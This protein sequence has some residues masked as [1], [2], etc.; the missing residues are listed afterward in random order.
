MKTPFSRSFSFLRFP[1]S[2]FLFFSTLFLTQCGKLNE[3]RVVGRNFE[4]EINLAQN[5]VF[6]FNKDIVPASELNSW[7]STKF[8]EFIPAVAGKFKWTAPNE[9][10]FSPASGF[11]PATEYRAEL[12]KELAKK[13]TDKKYGVSGEEIEF[14]T[15]Y[16]QLTDAETYWT[17]SRESGKPLAKTK[18]HFNYGVNGNEVV[19]KLKV[20][21]EDKSFRSSTTQ[22][23]P[24]EAITVV[25][26]DAAADK[27]E[28]PLE[29]SVEKGVKVPN[30]AYTTKEEI[31]L[32]GTIPSA[33]TLEV[34]DVK[35]GFENYRGVVRIIT[36][37]ELQNVDLA[38]YY[39][40]QPAV[41]T[42][43]ELTENGFTIRGDFNET[44]TYVLTLTDQVKGVLGAHLEE[45]ITKDLFFGNMPAS[46]S[47]VN[48]KAIYLSS[49]GA[50]NVGVQVVNIP[51]VQVKIAK[52]YE[53]NILQY[54]RTNRYEEYG[55]LGGEDN[56]GPTG[57]YTYEDDYNQVYSDI[58]VDKTIETDNLPKVKG[59][60]A[61]NLGLPDAP[62]AFRGI[63]VVTVQSKDEQYQRAVKMVSLSDIGLI[64]KQ[65]QD[66]FWVF[67][68][69]IKTAEPLDNL[70][71]S[72]IS[73]NNQT[74]LTGRT[75]SRGVA[76]FEKL[77]EKAPNFTIAMVIAK[78]APSKNNIDDDF[79]YLFLEDTQVETSRFE[80]EGKRDNTSGF[81][82]FIYG[83]RDIYRPG[84]TIHFNTV[85]RQQT[86]KSVGEIPLK[87]KVLLPNGKEL[88]SYR[89]NTNS[90]GAVE[91]SLVLDKAAVTGGYSVE[92]Y[93]GNDVLLASKKLNIEEFMPD[94]IKV[95][96]KTNQE[97]YR[98]GQAISLNATALNLFGP[99][100]SGR[101][102]EMEFSLKRKAFFA[103]RYKEYIFDMPDNATKFESVVRQ[104]VTDDNGLAKETFPL[105][106]EYQD[107]GVLEGKIYVTVFDETGRPV[108]RLKR[109][110][111]FTQDVFYGVKMAD[112]YVG[113]NAPVPIGLVAVDKD[114]KPKAT[115]TAQVEVIRMDY[116]TVVEKQN[117]QLRYASKKR[118]KIVYSNVVSF[119]NGLAE[120][121][122]V[123]TVSGEYEVRIRR[124]GSTGYSVINFYAYGWGSTSASSF[125]VSNEGEV[126]M[127][128]DKPNYKVGD[129]A[130]VLFKT[131][132]V[133]KLLVTVERNKVLEHHYL[134][135]DNKSAAFS[136]SVGS[137]HLPNAF[138]TAT[139]IRPLDNSNLPLTVAHGFASVKVEDDDTK[140]PVE[141]V[142][143]EKSRSKTKQKIRIKTAR[144]AQVT[145]AVVDE[146]IL[147]IKNFQTPDIHGFFY[148][149]RAL[150]VNSHDL[151]PFLF[152]ELSLASASSVGGDGY[153][154]EKRINPLSNGRVNLVAYW[155]G[156]IDAGF[157][158][159]AE[160][161]VDIP[162]FSGDL[163]IMAVAYKD[164]AF[165]SGNKNMKVA[166]PIVISTALPRFLSPDDE[167]I[168]PVNVT[169]TEKTAANV[170][171]SI[172][173]NGQLQNLQGKTQT[174]SI[175][176]EK[177]SRTAFVVKAA[178]AMGMGSVTVTVNNGKEKFVEKTELTIRP[179]TSL[180]KTSQSGIIAGGSAGTVDLSGNGFIPSTVSSKLVVSRSPMVQYAKALDY[181]LGYPHGC[182]EQT[183][184]KA[185][186]QLYFADIAKS[187]APKTYVVKTGESDF[188]P[189]FNVQAAIQKV[190]SM[191]LPNGAVSY[192]PAGT[193]ESPWGTAYATHFLL[194]AQRAGFEIN[195]SAVG[196][197]LD[198]LTVK[199][200][201][202]ATEYD[203]VYDE[204]S[205]Y[206][207]V[208]IGS[209]SSLYS[210]YALALGGKANRA[211]MNYY[212]QNQQL[213]TSD[214]RYLLA[215][216]FKQIGDE[217]SYY[218]LLP[219]T[220]AET[221]SSRQLSGSFASPIRNIALTLNTLIETDPNNIQ[222]P[223]LARRLS[224][225]LNSTAYLN[226]QEAAFSFLALGKLA[227][228]N[229]GSTVTAVVSSEKR[230]VSKFDGKDLIIT[231]PLNQK[232]QITASGKGPLY[233]FAQSEGLSA[234]GA[235]VEEDAGLR[236]RKQFLNRNGQPLSA[237]HQ[238]DLVVVKITLTST[239]GSPVEN[240][241]VT[242]LLPAAFEVEN[243][244]L[245]EPRDMPWIKNPTTPDHFDIRDDRIN[246]YTTA[247]NVEKTFYYMVRVITKGTFTLGPVSA[248]A[249]YSGDFRSYSGGGKVKVY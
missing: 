83:D 13:T 222:I 94:R 157:D 161:E 105:P 212:K 227:K 243:P 236:V 19:S 178:Q 48:K 112:N 231:K 89:L 88:K 58:I 153:D 100:A 248:D 207:Q 235:Y 192:W 123:P 213:L 73:S 80:V 150:E 51:K 239:D 126:L 44:D 224:Q 147:Q 59:V 7:E 52:I 111:V 131:P 34:K 16:L 46:I 188:N 65:G 182:I 43:A 155:S 184:S 30:T 116:Q 66:E 97:F 23:Q 18:L 217:R 20:K 79:N 194:E 247:N 148:Q 27:N 176:P 159:E 149:K 98:T 62:N 203:Y 133:G 69:S 129:K 168:V 172:S 223:T 151:Y 29:F 15:P 87:I 128:F 25:L 216:A 81:E 14:H 114:G 165:G 85:V 82:A 156:Q 50:R 167:L 190:E 221:R 60:S 67:A 245:T 220:L 17:K 175:A 21:S 215:A 127:E 2:I 84:E 125:E 140:L 199:T 75:D 146:G 121:R 166:D 110:D 109:F 5:L 186:P 92:V 135:T 35:T 37:Q 77:S 86:W 179:A 237:F 45:E 238:N 137:E 198:Y 93:N 218:A 103:D 210:L 95:D 214:T 3:I 113:L 191:Q 53:N 54:L 39:S 169:N 204:A 120:V 206:T 28:Q 142:A 193:E 202:P 119:K 185:F 136:F 244:R 219:A 132:F 180:L 201:T 158:G 32:S 115:A 170:Q 195:Q 102:Y 209:R 68:N 145:I 122:Y 241:V 144:N 154:L 41:Q 228:K 61:L 107:L 64:A 70:E 233:W 104:G 1:F 249:M 246:Y 230:V 189:T 162:Q 152:P 99:P 171:V 74:V 173:V 56:W 139:L 143:V 22:T 200:G 96:A 240:V 211:S 42:K 229:A 106:A 11:E 130:K 205:G 76:K 8:V 196:R 138:I 234:T 55:N 40:I 181:L 164:N 163:R 187:I 177:E 101:N 226:T 225:A 6:T 197:M 33:T 117:D 183:I 242:D 160:F 91:T 36:T 31:K 174:L 26:N 134:E 118:E 9:L 71:I 78:T 108:N 24:S 63:Y 49:K 141:I 72:L 232:L 47:F 57:N 10:I 124:V 12:S 208:T 90:E 4:D 38:S